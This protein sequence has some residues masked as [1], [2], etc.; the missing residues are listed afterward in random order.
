MGTE[1]SSSEHYPGG[2][3][4]G[5]IVLMGIYTNI[6]NDIREISLRERIIF[7]FGSGTALSIAWLLC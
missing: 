7:P 2:A 6:Y 4:M 5:I 1:I 3:M